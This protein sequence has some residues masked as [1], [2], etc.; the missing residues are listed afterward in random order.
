MKFHN[1][2]REYVLALDS[3]AWLK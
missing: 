2:A 3:F 1:G